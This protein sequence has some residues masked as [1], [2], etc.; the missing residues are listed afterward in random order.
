[1]AGLLAILARRN[2]RTALGVALLDGLNAQAKAIIEQNLGNY[3]QL[4][5]ATRRIDCIGREHRASLPTIFQFGD[6]DDYPAMRLTP[7]EVVIHKRADPDMVVWLLDHGASLTPC[8]VVR[9]VHELEALTES[10][11]I[12][13][14][15]GPLC[16]SNWIRVR[17]VVIEFAKRGALDWPVP[18]LPQV[19]PGPEV[20]AHLH[21]YAASS[22]GQILWDIIDCS[23]TREAWINELFQ[24][25]CPLPG[26]AREW[27]AVAVLGQALAAQTLLVSNTVP[28]PRL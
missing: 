3:P 16:L 25:Q 14:G 1:M 20:L 6:T 24:A 13:T 15:S 11:Q 17:A 22:V 23:L 8:A 26:G 12:A 18:A 28:L 4:I 9:A 19:V 2:A 10:G 7:L 27:L 21:R 5:N